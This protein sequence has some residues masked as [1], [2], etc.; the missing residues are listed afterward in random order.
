MYKAFKKKLDNYR[1]TSIEEAA[2]AV[3]DK[4]TGLFDKSEALLFIVYFGYDGDISK[5]DYYDLCSER[6]EALEARIQEIKRDNDGSD[7]FG[8]DEDDDTYSLD[9]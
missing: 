9:D 8:H 3:Y 6:P 2:N 1:P 7:I 4:E 5:E